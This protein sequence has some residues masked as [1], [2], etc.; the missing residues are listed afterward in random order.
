MPYK[1]TGPGLAAL[2]AGEVELMFDNLGTSLQHVRSGRLRAL[3]VCGE[4]RHATL[5]EVPAPI[6]VVDIFRNSNDALG[7]VRDA[8]A[9]REQL[10]VKV[11]WM[12]LGV[13]N[14]TASDEAEAAGITAVMDRCPK[15]ELARLGL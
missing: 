2:L 13:I 5:A 3:A 8:I 11:V 4:R 12:Q 14:A 6:D 7:V 9:L 1:G 15:I 10:G